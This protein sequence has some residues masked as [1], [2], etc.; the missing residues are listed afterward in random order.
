MAKKNS[1]NNERREMVAQ[2]RAEQAR[3]ERNRSL[4]ILGVCVVIV[5]G[6]LSAAV[7]PYVKDKRA[8]NRLKHTQIQN[9]GVKA[10]AAA[11]DAVVSRA[12]TGLDRSGA[13]GNHVN[14]GD[15]IKYAYSPPAFGQHWPNYLQSSE[16]RSF[17]TAAD[18]PDLHR[19]VH[20]LEHGHTLIWYDD[21]VKSGSADYK[22]LQDIANKYNGTTTYVNVLPWTS[23]D[24]G[25]G[26]FPAGKHI[27]I[28]HWSDK[29]NDQEGRWQY[30]GKVSG[31]VIKDFVNTYPSSDSPEAGAP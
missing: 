17:Y 16:Y 3:K 10:S 21:T 2:M 18:R 11:C 14:I 29:N 5:L 25:G 13:K 8:Q 26:T 4:L 30:C 27:A 15:D 12:P 23:S 24:N 7:V 31:A 22:A 9:L 6:L 19:M 28:T 1:K 20:S